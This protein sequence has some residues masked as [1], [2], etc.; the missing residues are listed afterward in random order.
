MDSFRFYQSNLIF[1]VCLWP[2]TDTLL[3][4]TDSQIQF[5]I[6]CNCCGTGGG[7]PGDQRNRWASETRIC[8]QPDHTR[9]AGKMCLYMK[10]IHGVCLP[11]KGLWI[12][13]E[14]VGWELLYKHRSWWAYARHRDGWVKPIPRI[15]QRLHSGDRQ[16]WLHHH[17]SNSKPSPSPI[18]I[19]T[20]CVM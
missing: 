5:L 14:I 12:L 18:T 8:G 6:P 9:T 2:Q 16:L 20:C 4:T 3:W 19:E 7:V 13:W 15:C 1:D 11:W 17:P 10:R